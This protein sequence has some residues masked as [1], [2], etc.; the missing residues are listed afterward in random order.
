MHRVSSGTLIWRL[1]TRTNLLDDRRQTAAWLGAVVSPG[2]AAHD[3][4]LSCGLCEGTS[5]KNMELISR[6]VLM[7]I[8]LKAE[9]GVLA[10]K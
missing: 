4:C 3:I 9:T 7:G 8:Q 2:V 1:D 10:G 5:G 6:A